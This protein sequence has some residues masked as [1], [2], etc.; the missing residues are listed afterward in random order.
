VLFFQRDSTLF[1][2]DALI[3]VF[4]E[5]VLPEFHSG[6]RSLLV[7]LAFD[8]GIFQEL[9][10]ELDVFDRDPG[11]GGPPSESV[12]PSEG[13]LDP[14][15]YRGGE[16]AFGF[17]PVV[18]P[19]FSVAGLS[20]PSAAAGLA[21]LGQGGFNFVSALG[22][23]GRPD[24]EPT[25][26]GEQGQGDTGGFGTRVDFDFGVLNGLGSVFEDDD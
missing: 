26:G 21:A 14:I 1:T 24:D 13:F 2:V 19:G 25:F 5:E 3:P 9:G 10:I 23:V 22:E 18:K 4:V 11:D 20:L 12:Y 16:P 15:D 8:V 7:F 6:E 17:R